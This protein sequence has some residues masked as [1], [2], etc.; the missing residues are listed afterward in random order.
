M[1][2]SSKSLRQH[3]FRRS[4]DTQAN[5]KIKAQAAGEEEEEGNGVE[6]TGFTPRPGHEA[7]PD[8]IIT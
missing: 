1:K 8:A 4:S 6:Q 7:V 2:E 5:R 3:P